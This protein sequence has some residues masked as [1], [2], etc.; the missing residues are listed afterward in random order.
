MGYLLSR[1]GEE[2]AA[3]GVAWGLPGD[4]SLPAPLFEAMSDP[5]QVAAQL[6]ALPP[7]SRQ[8]LLDLVA[9]GGE[10][11]HEALLAAL[12]WRWDDA[13]AA[14]A[15]LASRGLAVRAG[16]GGGAKVVVPAEAYAAL[17]QATSAGVAA[18]RRFTL[19][20]QLDRLP[21]AEI[22]RLCGVWGLTG[23]ATLTRPGMQA[24]LLRALGARSETRRLAGSLSP[25]ARRLLVALHRSGGLAEATALRLATGLDEGELRLG[26]V[27]AREVFPLQAAYGAGR[28]WLLLPV[29]LGDLAEPESGE[30]SLLPLPGEATGE[31]SPLFAL[32][33]ALLLAL[34]YLRWAEP[35]A[36]A[37]PLARSHAQRLAKLLDG[38]L[39]VEA[40]PFAL[41]AAQGLDLIEE[42]QGRVVP[43]ARADAWEL[44]SFP[45]Q[46]LATLS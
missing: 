14:V 26:F 44:L 17:L 39:P 36:T 4:R 8:A 9:A 30:T 45:A 29:G 1:S 41:A 2:L 12:P 22:E 38:T 21:R 7:A 34:D 23:L 20:Q 46:A 40:I 27:E 37:V 13:A 15:T 43:G 31:Q 35:P 18:P 5:W 19:R 42:R 28:R 11:A 3:L 16:E 10:S 6:E 25:A 24:A 32:P 33:T